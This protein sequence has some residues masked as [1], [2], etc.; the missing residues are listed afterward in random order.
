MSLEATR[1]LSATRM[2][3]TLSPTARTRGLILLQAETHVS[4]NSGKQPQIHAAASSVATHRP[5]APRAGTA[6]TASGHGPPR[7]PSSPAPR[8]SAGR[9]GPRP[10]GHGRSGAGGWI[11]HPPARAEG[12]GR[13]GPRPAGCPRAR[14]PRARG[15]ARHQ[16]R[17]LRRRPQGQAAAPPPPRGQRSA[18]EPPSPGS[19]GRTRPCRISCPVPSSLP[20]FPSTDEPRLL[21]RPPQV[22]SPFFPAYF[23]AGQYTSTLTPPEMLPASKLS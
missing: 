2:T 8:G 19:S 12:G 3:A 6:R 1:A 23:A 13:R 7:A 14:R 11:P 15:A 21:P 9:A 10:A 20:A 18:P 5:S 17:E 16:V 4:S 22:P